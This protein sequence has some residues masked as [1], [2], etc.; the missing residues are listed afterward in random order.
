M[1]VANN[2]AG[3]TAIFFAATYPNRTASLVLD[4]CWA[5]LARAPDYPFGIPSDVLEQAVA[6][7][8][9]RGASD[10]VDYTSLRY[11]APEAMKD[12]EFFAQFKR[13]HRNT[14]SPSAA[15]LVGEFAA[16]ADVRPL[17]P[18]IQAPTLVLYRKGDQLAGKAHATYLAQ[19][20]PDATLVEVPGHDNLMWVGNN[21]ADL[22]EIEEFLTGVRHVQATDR[23]LATVLFTDIVGSTELA[24]QLGDWRWRDMLD[25][26]DRAVRRQL[27]RFRGREVNTAGDGF[28]ATFDGP[29]RAIEC[30]CAI[31][32]AVKALGIE[33]R[34]GVHTGEIE[35]R[36]EDVAGMAVHIGA[37][38]AA[39]AG[40][41]QVLVSSTVKDLVAGSGIA[42]EDQ[43]EHELKGL[44]GS[45]R[46]YG[47]N[48]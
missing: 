16:Y 18:A 36:G 24:G 9:A 28:L 48:A 11:L 26:H 46:L 41:G 37:R 15:G 40:P 38:V 42:F 5:R 47:V 45:W 10:P 6:S 19:H 33:V 2:A 39:I 3:L 30:G 7:V 21:Y 17:L 22:E 8:G 35:M 44:P 20:I 25:A 34:V 32:D 27:E 1:L 31:R 4:G 29:G 23:V 13:Y 14:S 12:P 43:G